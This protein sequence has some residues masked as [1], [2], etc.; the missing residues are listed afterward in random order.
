KAQNF[1]TKVEIVSTDTPEGMQFKQ[2]GG[3]GG[4]LRYKL[5]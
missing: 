5:Q 1:G 4:F 2:L 3:I